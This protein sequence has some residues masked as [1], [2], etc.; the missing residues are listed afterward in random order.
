M[1]LLDEPRTDV[2]PENLTP[3]N[4]IVSKPVSEMTTEERVRAHAILNFLSKRID[5]R[6]AQLREPILT[7]AQENG[8][9]IIAKNGKPT[10]TRKLTVNGSDVQARK[11]VSK[12]PDAAKMYTLLES[13]GLDVLKAYDS[14]KNYVYNPS[15]VDKL[16]ENGFLTADEVEDLKKTTHTL[17]VEGS[18]ELMNWLEERTWKSL[19]GK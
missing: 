18:Y 2:S 11:T 5:A 3:G 13:K 10:G 17:I 9:P 14:C 7:D 4:P 1:K 8:L 12:E 15:K 6:L 19:S 16:I